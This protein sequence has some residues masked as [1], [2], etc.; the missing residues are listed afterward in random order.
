MQTECG[1]ERRLR[2]AAE[3]GRR[4]GKDLA[5]VGPIALRV[6]MAA[7]PGAIE[8]QRRRIETRAESEI[9]RNRPIRRLPRRAFGE[10][11]VGVKPLRGLQEARTDEEPLETDLAFDFRRRRQRVGEKAGDGFIIDAETRRGV[12]GGEPEEAAPG[13]ER[14]RRI[15]VVERQFQLQPLRLRR[16]PPRRR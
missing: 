11:M 16:R 2:G 14:R 15:P 5:D 4:V 3:F 12:V 7:G 13:G 1:A 6:A 9:D 8:R 10:T